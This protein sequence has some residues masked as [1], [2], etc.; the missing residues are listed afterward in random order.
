MAILL[1]VELTPAI[2]LW[3]LSRNSYAEFIGRNPHMAGIR[4]MTSAALLALDA[5]KIAEKTP[6]IMGA[7][8]Y[9]MIMLYDSRRAAPLAKLFAAQVL[10]AAWLAVALGTLAG[11]AAGGDWSIAGCGALVAASTPFAMIRSLDRRLE[12]KKRQILFALPE[13]LNQLALLVNA[14]ET[15]QQAIV[16]CTER[17]L[18]GQVADERGKS[19]P[20]HPWLEH[21]QV[22]AFQLA[23]RVP[24]PRAM[25]NL[26]K[27][28][29]VQEVT[30]FTTTILL[31]YRRG[32]EDLL[33]AL[34]GLGRDLWERRKAMART[35]GE[36]AS[37]K[38]VFPMVLIFFVVL[39]V[40]AAPAILMMNN[41]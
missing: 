24:F 12:R 13:F 9:R 32:G 25:E 3:I 29:A 14:G 20:L 6:R 31:N 21:L 17:M 28:C 22:M 7:I 1:A 8:H 40:V 39:V 30:L 37:A 27:R 26:S 38:L 33:V 4:P 11:M 2:G 15:L 23:N 19:D 36:E 34:R 35:M 10:S 5:S 41:G 18:A 16:H